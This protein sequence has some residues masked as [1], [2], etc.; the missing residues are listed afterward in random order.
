VA[1]SLIAV[2]DKI[3]AAVINSIIRQ[4]NSTAL[5][6][7]VPTSVAGTGVTVAPNGA[8]TFTNA[9][10][11]SLNGVFSGSYDNYRITWNST[12]RSASGSTQFRFRAAGTDAVTNYDFVKIVASGTTS[13]VTSSSSSS[14][15]PLD[16]GVAAGQTSDGVMDLFGPALNRMV[17]GTAQSAVVASSV[18]YQTNVAIAQEATSSFDGFTMY[19]LTTGETWTGTIRVYGYN[20]LA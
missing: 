5:A 6:G 15:L 1:I 8:V 14:G 12:T 20:T 7:I 19:G 3:K 13:T 10:T 16:N 17:T 18:L 9:T 2:G 11:V 4:V